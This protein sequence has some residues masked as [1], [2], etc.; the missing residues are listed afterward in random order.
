MAERLYSAKAG[1]IDPIGLVGENLAVWYSKSWHIYTIDFV[2]QMPRSAN[3]VF[4][5]GALAAL[6]NSGDVRLTNLD[7]NIDPPGLIQLRFYP[8]DDI[9]VQVKIQRSEARFTSA[10]VSALVDRMTEIADPCLHTTEIVV[11]QDKSLY[12][13]CTNPTAYATAMS[14][15]AFFGFRY[16]LRDYNVSGKTREEVRSILQK[17]NLNQNICYVPSG[18]D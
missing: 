4:D 7:Q 9:Q 6:A 10:N 13:N 17:L 11:L 1:E 12:V 2:E 8:L 15:V 16:M 5:Q 3:L 14:R 18:R